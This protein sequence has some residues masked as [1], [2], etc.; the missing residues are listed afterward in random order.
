M[1]NMRLLKKIKIAVSTV[2]IILVFVMGYFLGDGLR[3]N[4]SNKTIANT[5]QQTKNSNKDIEN[6]LRE[7]TKGFLIAFYTKKDLGENRDRYR[8]FVTEGMYN[9]I[10]ADEEKAVNK[11][12]QG[13]IVDWEYQEADMYINSD[14]L[15]VL[16]N[17]RY[18][19][20][21]LAI[22]DDKSK[23]TTQNRQSSYK[24]TFTKLD[25]KLLINKTDQMLIEPVAD[26]KL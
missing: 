10:V 20:T 4:S 3:K 22:K 5:I 15:E 19:N 11:A 6:Q 13:Y 16:V 9:S 21:T 1:L 17:V 8:P 2:V 12:Y 18:K 25:N 26:R 7:Q 14:K 24:I 23:Q